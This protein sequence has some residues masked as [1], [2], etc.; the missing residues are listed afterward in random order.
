MSDSPTAVP[1]SRARPTGA[2]LVSGIVTFAIMAG[3]VTQVLYSRNR[4]S[5]NDARVVNS[6]P[7]TVDARFS[8]DAAKRIRPGDR[9]L[10]TRRGAAVE[11][12]RVE[13]VAPL[14]RVVVPRGAA[15]EEGARCE[16]TIDT[17]ARKLR[18]SPTPVPSP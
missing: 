9:A 14:V 18:P 6:S 1:S 17:E 10:L 5:T 12:G 11:I 13:S 8:P 16:V 7:L 15:W 2:W 3:F 4:V